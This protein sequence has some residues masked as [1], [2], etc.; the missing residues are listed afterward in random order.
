M[1][2]TGLR[3]N[4]AR[5]LMVADVD[6]AN[7]T[8][9]VRSETS[10]FRKGRTVYMHKEVAYQL[11]R[12]V[13]NRDNNS[14][15]D[16]RNAPLRV[17]RSGEPFTID[18]FGKIFLRLKERSGIKNFSAHVCRHTWAADFMKVP[19]ASLLETQASGRLGEVGDAGAV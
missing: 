7:C 16:P 2:G 19:N 11:D 8:V 17:N 12:Y 6:F 5:A 4:E 14:Q 9:T 3:L 1:L 15:N 18:S 13:R 10:K